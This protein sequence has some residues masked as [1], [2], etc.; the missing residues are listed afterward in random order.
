MQLVT[1][2]PANKVRQSVSTVIELI[3][4]IGAEDLARKLQ[5]K[6]ALFL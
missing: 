4:A 3:E 6:L 2:Q 1:H 5:K